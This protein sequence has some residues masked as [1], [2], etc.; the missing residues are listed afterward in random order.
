MAWAIHKA[1]LHLSLVSQ[2]GR[3]FNF[4]AAPSHDTVSRHAAH[5]DQ[6][7]LS[8][9]G[10]LDGSFAARLT[11][12]PRTTPPSTPAA[13]SHPAPFSPGFPT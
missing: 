12:R 4:G 8:G 3:S 1:E 9:V 2:L 6:S 5:L 13:S 7:K 10:G 11:P